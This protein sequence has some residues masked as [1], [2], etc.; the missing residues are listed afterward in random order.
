MG[1]GYG[2]C[3]WILTAELGMR[4]VAAK[5]VPMILIADQKQQRVCKELCQITSEDATFLSRFI[6]GDELDLQL[7]S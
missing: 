1:I 6:N 2:T 5:L 3:Q 7:R 4:F